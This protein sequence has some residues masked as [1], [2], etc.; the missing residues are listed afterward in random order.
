MWIRQLAAGT[1]RSAWFSTSTW[2][3]ARLRKSASF[4]SWNE[5]WW[6]I[7]RSGQSSC[8]TNPASTIASYSCCIAAAMQQ[9]Y[10]A[11][12]DAGFVLQ[13]DCPDL[14]MAHHTS[15]QDLSETDFLK[16]AAFHVEA[17]NHALRN[18]P[19]DRCRIHICWGNYEGPHDHDIAFAKVAPILIKA[20]PM[21][22]V[23]EAANP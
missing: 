21:A 15:F 7:A 14:A 8:R 1:L 6:A 10:E 4:K 2:N 5:V 12:V 16:R 20:K 11:I 9:E 23:V 17:L 22:L 3:E 13:L 18:V 19:A